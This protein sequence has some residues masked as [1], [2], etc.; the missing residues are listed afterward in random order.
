[1]WTGQKLNAIKDVY[2]DSLWLLYQGSLNLA[3]DGQ[4]KAVGVLKDGLLF[5]ERMG[6]KQVQNR[7]LAEVRRYEDVEM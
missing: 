3:E 7:F 2:Y 6:D 4:K 1:M 5:A